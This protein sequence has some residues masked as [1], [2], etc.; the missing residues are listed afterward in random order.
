LEATINQTYNNLEILA[1]NDGSTDGSLDIL[2][3]YE[4][5]DNR[6]RIINQ[7]NN[8]QASARNHGLDEAR[9]D[10][11]YMVDSDDFIAPNL[12][13]ECVDT[14]I[15]TNSDLIVFDF[16]QINTTGKRSLIVV[17]CGINDASTVLWNKFYKKSLWKNYRIPEG[18]WY[19]DLGIVPIIMANA[20]KVTKLNQA[21]YYYFATRSSSQSNSIDHTKINDTILMLEMVYE[22][23]ERLG[24]SKKYFYQLQQ[25]FINHLVQLSILTKLTQYGN[26]KQRKYAMNRINETMNKYYPNWKTYKYRF[27]NHLIVDLLHRF[28]INKY[29]G[30]HYN[31]ANLIWKFYIFIKSV[32]KIGI[33]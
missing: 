17:G 4:R 8:G 11:I 5:K 7:R 19:E 18:Y 28:I 20:C 26:N 32:L 15:R 21:L 31:V 10:Y 29:F 14:V 23:F 16:Y 1:I 2:R 30:G 27:S 3:E 6:I 13:S 9:G 24:I 22:E 25:L 33:N 12:I